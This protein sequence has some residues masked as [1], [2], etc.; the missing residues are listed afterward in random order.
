MSV[1]SSARGKR[2][3]IRD[4]AREAGVSRGT[5]SRVLNGGE[6]VSPAALAAVQAAIER[7]GYVANKHARS[8]ASGRANTM[9]FLLTEPHHLL[10][11]DPNFSTLLRGAA[12]ALSVRDL[13]LVLVLA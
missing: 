11:E 8:L 10:F 3:T 2:P 1:A 6:Y 13:P 12:Q 5:V 4:I 7:T 9:A